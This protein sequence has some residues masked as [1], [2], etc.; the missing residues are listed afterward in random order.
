M[1]AKVR[2]PR[3]ALSDFD[4]DPHPPSPDQIAG[5]AGPLLLEFGASWCGICRSAQ[6]MVSAALAAYPGVQHLRVADS[7]GAR[8]GRRFGVK[9]WPTFI[10]LLDGREISRLVRPYQQQAIEAELARIAPAPTDTGARQNA[11]DPA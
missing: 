8:L 11:A 7:P 5:L 2:K 10:F 4:Y 3:K 9:L 6:T 1:H